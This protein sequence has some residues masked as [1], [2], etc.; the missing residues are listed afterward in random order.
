MTRDNIV[1][2]CK[3]CNSSKKDEEMLSWFQKQPFYKAERAQKIFD[4]VD[5]V[6]NVDASMKEDNGELIVTKEV[7]KEIV[8]DVTAQI[9]WLK[10]RKPDVWRDKWEL[11]NHE[12]VDKLDNILAELKKAAEKEQGA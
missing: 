5:L 7:T 1:P 9:Y 3:R 10:N 4:Y 6:I 2:C 8:P 12:E 11:E